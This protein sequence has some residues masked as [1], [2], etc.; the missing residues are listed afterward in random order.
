MRL[1]GFRGG[2][3]PEALKQH[4]ADHEIT[5]L[6]MPDQ[7]YIPLQQ[8][9]GQP[10]EPEVKPGDHVYKGQLLARSQGLISAPVHSPS[11]GFIAD[12]TDFPA[13]HDS[14]PLY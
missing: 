7:L 1:F 12:I 8:H 2:V 11:S 3:H 6:P 9:V 13:P 10:A 5:M 14:T 4:T